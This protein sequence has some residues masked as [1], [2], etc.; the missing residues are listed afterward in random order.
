MLKMDS[1]WRTSW[2]SNAPMWMIWSLFYM[3]EWR[4]ANKEV[5]S[6]TR[7]LQEAIQFLQFIWSAKP[8]TN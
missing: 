2:S 6:L 5:M 7:I 8:N 1:S 3:R 4:I